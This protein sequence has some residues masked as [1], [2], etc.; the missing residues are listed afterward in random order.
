MA[1]ILGLGGI[2]GGFLNLVSTGVFWIIAIFLLGLATIGSLWIRKKRKLRYPAIIL[3]DLGRGKMGIEHTRAGWFKS[4]STFF[5]LWDYGKE[6]ILK[7]KDGRKI[8]SASTVDFHEIDGKRGLIAQKKSDDNLILVPLT[9]LKTENREL[10][11]RIA[12]A[13]LRDASV[14]I[15][16]QAEQ[17]TRNKWAEMAQWIIFGGL[18]IFSLIS[19]ILITQMVKNGQKEAADLIL[20]AGRIVGRTAGQSTAP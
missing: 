12:P 3:N 13:D 18:I 19:I 11:A 6:E 5:G 20:E 4:K 1:G 17:E 9:R 10:L 14:D 15:V 2:G 7:V 16:K 8:Q